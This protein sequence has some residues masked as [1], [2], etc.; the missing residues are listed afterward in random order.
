MK[1]QYIFLSVLFLLALNIFCWREVFALSE[2]KM[3]EVDF[4]D[5]GQ[6]DSIFIK[7]PEGHQIIIDGGP[8]S[9]LLQKLAERM[10]FWDKTID[11]ITGCSAKLQSGLF[12]MDRSYKK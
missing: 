11:R 7:T 10:P 12:F 5:V 1:R 9:I 6:G 8:N 3:L 2:E 4:L